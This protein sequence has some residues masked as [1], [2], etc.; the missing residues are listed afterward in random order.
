MD[1]VNALQGISVRLNQEIDKR[2]AL[3]SHAPPPPLADPTDSAKAARRVAQ[4]NQD[5]R[6]AQRLLQDI[7]NLPPRPTSLLQG[8]LTEMIEYG[9]QAYFQTVNAPSDTTSLPF[10]GK[11]IGLF[12]ATRAVST[13][14]QALAVSMQS[15]CAKLNIVSTEAP[16][17][18]D[19]LEDCQKNSVEYAQ[20]AWI[21]C[22]EE[23]RG[24]R[25][26]SLDHVLDGI[27]DSR[28]LDEDCLQAMLYLLGQKHEQIY[29]LTVVT[30]N[31]SQDPY[32]ARDYSTLGYQ[33][34]AV[35][36]ILKR[37]IPN[38]DG[39]VKA[40][41]SGFVTREE[42]LRA[43]PLIIPSNRA[44]TSRR[45][46]TD[47]SGTPGNALP[48]DSP[49]PSSTR[50][51]EIGRR[52]GGGRARG[53]T[54]RQSQ[55]RPSKM[56]A[57][58]T[59]NPQNANPATA[60]P[61]SPADPQSPQWPQSLFQRTGL[62]LTTFEDTAAH[63]QANTPPKRSSRGRGSTNISSVVLHPGPDSPQALPK[64]VQ[65]TD[66]NALNPVITTD[67]R[68]A[69]SLSAGARFPPN[70]GGSRVYGSA[71]LS[72]ASQNSFQPANYN[73]PYPSLTTTSSKESCLSQGVR[74]LLNYPTRVYGSGCPFQAS[75]SL[76]RPSTYVS[77]YPA[78]EN[79]SGP[80]SSV[81]SVTHIPFDAYDAT[82]QANAGYP[83]R[84]ST[85]L[86]GNQSPQTSAQRAG[87][88]DGHRSSHGAEQN[89]G[90]S[91][92]D[93]PGLSPSNCYRPA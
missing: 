56:R 21:I 14:F 76:T 47:R 52:R 77:P 23:H 53:T 37:E 55:L 30:S 68:V 64:P 20:S 33:P 59:T 1:L 9:N 36:R 72:Q 51:R 24:G 41:W 40:L 19:W 6:C 61:I 42:M 62:S 39:S 4:Q 29:Q 10:P 13:M 46:A 26:G 81:Y 49:A 67:L 92:T 3:A 75:Q 80:R 2:R 8:P 84:P 70:A 93:G 82:A 45:Q 74:Y 38:S 88:A 44:E 28:K 78:L 89:C 63:F 32:A 31:E 85:A 83:S 73:D 18:G 79:P 5:Q 25:R 90:A 86:G 60:Q 12:Y 22:S 66:H 43:K 57:G 50:R 69:S 58:A 54:R 87:A 17:I 34:T 65:P 11:T 27:L 91:E 7:Q 48:V 16:P 35:V 71:D 15:V